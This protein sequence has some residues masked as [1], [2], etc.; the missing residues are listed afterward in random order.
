MSIRPARAV[1][2]GAAMLWSVSFAA[3]ALL[4]AFSPYTASAA[5]DDA[6]GVLTKMSALYTNAKTYQSTV[7][8][9]ESSKTQDGKAYSVTTT[10]EIRYK[11]PNFINMTMKRTGTGAAAGKKPDGTP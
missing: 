1:Q 6:P 8:S 4:L 5:G 10:Q 7:V 2:H 9:K 11:A 3:S